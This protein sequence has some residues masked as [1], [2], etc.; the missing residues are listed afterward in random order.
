MMKR[1]IIEIGRVQQSRERDEEWG[2]SCCE[3]WTVTDIYRHIRGVGG[4]FNAV[5]P[6]RALLVES[7]SGS[8][9]I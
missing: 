9:H 8:Y 4:Q 3:Q 5:L 6:G 7:W 2:E 1:T